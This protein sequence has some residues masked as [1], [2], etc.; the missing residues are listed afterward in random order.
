MAH[1][2]QVFLMNAMFRSL[3][4]HNYRLWAAGALISNIGTWMQRTAQDWLV[5]TQLTHHN[6]TSVGVVT[7]LQFGPQLLFLPLTGYAADRFDKRKL[8]LATQT[9]S[10]VLA[11]VLGLLT[12]SGLV[13]LWHVYVLA[14]LLGCSTAFDAPARQAFVSELVGETDLVNAVGLNSTSF[15]AA[16]LLGPAA[17]G[18][19]ISA[20]GTGW[21]FVVNAA[22][23]VAVLA[24]LLLLRTGQLHRER[25]ERA[26]LHGLAEGFAYVRRRPDL[27]AILVMMGFI[28]TFG[29][30]YPVFISTM[31][32]TVFH[33]GA[34]RYGM[35]TSMMAVGSVTGALMAARRR[36]PR[37][38]RLYI[39]ASVFGAAFVLAAF[40]P[41]YWA[42]GVCLIA[43]G[44]SAQTLTTTATSTVQLTTEP[45]MR[46]RVMAILL[47][48]AMGGMPVGAPIV[49]WVADR[50]GPRWALGVGAASG[51]AAALVGA[52]AF[53]RKVTLSELRLADAPSE[54]KG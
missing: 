38:D 47:A 20:V 42:F 44:V 53:A 32:V 7:A 51:F 6:A 22:S 26:A 17:A 16:R 31:S 40:A 27:Q 39:A 43:V 14:F 5:L 48:V 11:F 24:A 1:S 45:A 37:P 12:L 50:F 4:I 8:L 28:G 54:V 33:G 52:L 29:L 21:A 18:V 19:M 41:N 9:I 46:G 15:N 13:Q 23:Y 35:L 36:R 30:N 10:G 2:P 34:H 25:G 3:R 49:G